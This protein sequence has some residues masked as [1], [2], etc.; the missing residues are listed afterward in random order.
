VDEMKFNADG[1]V[2]K[3]IP[4]KEGPAQI[5]H[6][7]PFV[8]V[9]AETICWTGG[10]ETQPCSEGGMNVCDVNDGDFIKVKGVDFGAGAA[11]FEARVASATNGGSIEICLDSPTGTLVGTCAVSGTGDWQTWVTTSCGVNDVTGVHDVYLVFTGGSG[12]LMNINWWRF[13]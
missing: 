9:E 6:L 13:K 1:S 5:G 2:E 11:S 10:V 7:D 4:T 12:L 8:R 3:V